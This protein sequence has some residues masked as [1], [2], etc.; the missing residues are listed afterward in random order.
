MSELLDSLWIEKYRPKILNDLVLPEKYKLDFQRAIE[1]GSLPNLLFSGPPG[2]GKTTLALILCSKNGVLFN[3][4]DNMLMANGSS[5]KHRSINFVE[6]T[7]EPFLKHPPAGDKY[8]I[9]FIDEA[10]NLSPDSFKA[11]RGIIEKYHKAYGRFIWTCNYISK[12]PDPVQSRFTPY[13][14]KQIPKEFLIKYCE[15][16]LIN[17]KIK[18]EMKDIGFV[19]N[20]LYPDVRKIVNILQRCCWD[21]KL[22]VDEEAVVTTEKIITAHIIEIISL[23]AQEQPNKIGKVVNGIIEILANIDLEYRSIYTDL[24]FNDKIPAPAKIIIN[25]Y[26]NEHQGCLIPHQ[27]FMA[28]VF[29]V[30]KALREYKLVRAG[31]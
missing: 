8:K 29:D 24:F 10:D 16:I 11:W 3:K 9:V 15:D 13:H 1:R 6:N 2:G 21:G 12:I 18:Y 17:E 7:V 31:K 14:F 4:R 30:I 19:I 27:H 20:Q 5:K 22:D 25:K 28:M 23:I 26:A